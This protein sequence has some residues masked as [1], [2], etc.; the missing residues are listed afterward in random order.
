MTV[1]GNEISDKES[2]KQDGSNKKSGK[3]K[4]RLYDQLIFKAWCKSCGICIAFC[5]KN[6]IGKNEAGEPVIERPDDCIGCRFCE[7]HCPDFAI[8]ILERGA[9]GETGEHE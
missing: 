8:T 3:K 1:Q 6:V 4:K 2:S 7:I 5:P 9:E